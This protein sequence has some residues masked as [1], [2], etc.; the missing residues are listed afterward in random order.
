MAI[1]RSFAQ[2]K[3]GVSLTEKMI[4]TQWKGMLV[5]R[6]YPREYNDQRTEG[7]VKV[8]VNMATFS[9][10]WYGKLNEVRRAEWEALAKMLGS[11][12]EQEKRF[13]C[14]MGSII[15]VG[16]GNR[17]GVLMTGHDLFIRC[18][19]LAA[20]SGFTYSRFY[21]PLITGIPPSP[22]LMA[23]LVELNGK[24]AIFCW[25]RPP[26]LTN[27]PNDK[28]YRLWIQVNL[29]GVKM[30]H[31]ME[32][33]IKI[34][35]GLPQLDGIKFIDITR[36]EF[37]SMGDKLFHERALSDKEMHTDGVLIT[38]FAVDNAKRWGREWVG[39]SDLDTAI[40]KLQA[41]TI[42]AD[43]S[44]HGAVRSAPSDLGIVPL[45]GQPDNPEAIRLLEIAR[46]YRRDKAAKYRMRK[47][48]GKDWT[49][50]G[51]RTTA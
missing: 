44:I 22:G 18:N 33:V 31:R 37:K 30:A 21:A 2:M 45:P 13:T 26:V 20:N 35:A 43:T 25:L 46:Q 8:R 19:M 17:Q 36:T 32:K 14:S 27:T 10:L 12:Y 7:Q 29:R 3:G 11:A 6:S 39:F 23:E 50:N 1:G 4:A 49:P 5:L 9:P 48:Y 15:H 28:A 34:G 24:V 41:E 38:G 47:K 42:V 16:R 40:V 51:E